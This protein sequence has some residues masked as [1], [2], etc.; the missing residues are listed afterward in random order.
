MDK[1]EILKLI[2]QQIEVAIEKL[3][4]EMKIIKTR[5]KVKSTKKL[6]GK[7]RTKN[8]HV[9]LIDKVKN[10]RINTKQYPLVKK[11]DPVLAKCLFVLNIA[12][13][14]AGIDEL[15]AAQIDF[16]APYFYKL[17]ISR[18]A[19]RKALDSHPELINIRKESDKII[20]YS[21]IKEGIEYYKNYEKTRKKKSSK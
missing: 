21:V 10:I 19:A 9:E 5:K 20:F 16:I 2:N 3:R 17:K 4:R 13:K 11:T 18:Q 14:E 12:K 8:I 15:T 7:K 1:Q 6:I